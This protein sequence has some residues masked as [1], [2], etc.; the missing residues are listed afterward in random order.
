M[1]KGRIKYYIIINTLLILILS[2]IVFLVVLKLNNISVKSFVS[3]LFQQNDS[4]NIVDNKETEESTEE[5][6][7]E[8]ETEEETEPET[9]VVEDVYDTITISAAGDVTLGR[10]SEYGYTGSFDHE[11]ELQDNDYSYFFRNVK[12]VFEADDIT[13]VNLET[14]LTSA[15]KKADKSFR[16]KADPSYVEIL[17]EGSIEAVSIA[18]NHSRDYL[19]E[20]YQDTINTLEDADVGYFGYE[21]KYLEDI[22]V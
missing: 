3:D 21:H 14:T 9:E 18:N 17:K 11:L 8:E 16:F 20:G 22:R 7:K 1:K 12:D 19:E 13:L 4:D 10:D 15:T 5:E 6:T 2:I